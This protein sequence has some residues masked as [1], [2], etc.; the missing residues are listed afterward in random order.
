MSEKTKQTLIVYP[1]INSGDRV[2]SLLVKDTGEHLASHMCS[3][4]GF[5]KSDL[6]NGRPERIEAFGKRFGE[7]EVLFIDESDITIEELLARNKEWYQG[8]PIKN[9]NQ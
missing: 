7:I 1:G 6:Y 3:H 8:L 9:T 4:H 2:Y 5:A